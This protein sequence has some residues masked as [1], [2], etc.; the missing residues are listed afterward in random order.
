[1]NYNSGEIANILDAT[2][3]GVSDYAVS[4]ISIDSRSISNQISKT[5]FI[6]LSGNI[7]DGHT[8][9]QSAYDLG[10]RVFLID[11]DVDL[12]SD[13]ITI[14]VTNT[15]KALQH[16]S[17]I[18]RSKFDIPV[19]AITGSNGKTITKEWL[20]QL[21]SKYFNVVKS[22]KSFNSQIGVPLS[23][24]QMNDT[25]EVAVFEVGIS[26]ANEM[27]F[28]EEIIKPTICILTNIG[29]AH[30][31]GFEGEGLENLERKLK[32][33]SIL[34]KECKELIFYSGDGTKPYILDSLSSIVNNKI[35]CP[36]SY[37][38]LEENKVRFTFSGETVDLY[39]PFSDD[40]S[41]QN[42]LAS[43]SVMNLL[44]IKCETIEEDLMHLNRVHMRMET[45]AG[46]WNSILIND[47]Y[48][49]DLESL[50]NAVQYLKQIKAT[51]PIIILSDL[52]DNEPDNLLYP[53]VAE[54]LNTIDH[55]LITVGESSQILEKS[56]PSHT[57]HYLDT[58]EVF[59]KRSGIEGRT[60][61]LKG[62]R[63]YKFEK[64]F[65]KFSAQS[66]SAYL[67]VDLSSMEHNL[68]VYASIIP[69]KAK[70]MTVIKASA[71]GSGASELAK[72]LQH[73]QVA[74]MAVAYVDEGIQLRESGI[75]TPILVLNPDLDQLEEMVTYNLEPEV[76]SVNQLEHMISY[77]DQ[78]AQT[79]FPAIHLKLDTGMHRLG[80][81]KNDFEKL[82]TLLKEA[83]LKV[84]SIFS[85]LS[86]SDNAIHDAY[87]LEQIALFEEMSM[88][89]IEV[90]G[91]S[92]IRHFAN[93]AAISRYPQ[94]HYDMVRLGIGLYGIDG[95]THTTNQLE[96]VHTLKAK[97]I[98][99]KSVVK[100]ATVGYNRMHT[101]Q[102]DSRIAIINIGYADGLMRGS[103]N[104]KHK[105]YLGG[106]Y[107]P[108]IGNVCMDLTIIDITDVA[109][110]EVG[111]DVEIFGKQVDITA[112]AKLN[113]TIPYELLAGISTRVKKVYVRS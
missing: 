106:K 94:A 88:K 28:L 102:R 90:L 43:V 44:G 27:I 107:V 59:I 80:F 1:M 36:Y 52:E 51:R 21:L 92:P 53:K 18:H 6:A 40:A 42:T 95:H 13:A 62:A 11:R 85:H 54:I 50:S 79:I 49:S 86:S 8:Y 2:L 33:K 78:D 84:A 17:A 5:I 41:I 7:V 12:P 15:L 19:I 74:Y 68:S 110:A 31:S 46:K 97:I 39:L 103:G 66:H 47:S 64:L 69:S 60:I 61:L 20:S 104:G 83:K 32:E 34:F 77:K 3:V 22:P 108:I 26:Q 45:K 89:L 73:R 63:K 55:I 25:H 75:Q 38:L 35:L 10:V 71:Y 24:L 72:H 113:N 100:G 56:V 105:V 9:V 99:I 37:G 87:N 58:D 23:V 112:L 14:K 16:W 70:I 48:N 4:H 98:Q 30:S 93:T 67:E 96:R 29:D 101:L 57:H 76:Y 109:A 65:E 91:Y 111:D 82:F 81:Q